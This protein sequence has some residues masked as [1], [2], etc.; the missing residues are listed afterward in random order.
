M[1]KL[2]CWGPRRGEHARQGR[3]MTGGAGTVTILAQMEDVAQYAELGLAGLAFGNILGIVSLVCAF[4][5]F[6]IVS[7]WL[8][9]LAIA[10]VLP[11]LVA[12][13]DILRSYR[14]DVAQLLARLFEW[15][16]TVIG[17]GQTL[18]VLFGGSGLIISL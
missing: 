11:W 6:R 1:G 12:E 8:G 16:M 7:P 9:L 17:V 15:P 5:R 10:T 18:A 3:A 13:W 14:W 4:T 2:D